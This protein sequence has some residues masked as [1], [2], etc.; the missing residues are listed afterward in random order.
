MILPLPG[1]P[2]I[3]YGRNC[4]TSSHVP[5]LDMHSL[6]VVS[7]CR[8]NSRPAVRAC[9]APTPD[10]CCCHALPSR[11]AGSWPSPSSRAPAAR[12]CPPSCCHCCRTASAPTCFQSC[13]AAWRSYVVQPHRQDACCSTRAEGEMG[14]GRSQRAGPVPA[15]Q[16]CGCVPRLAEG[17]QPSSV[18]NSARLHTR[19]FGQSQASA[20]PHAPQG[21][22]LHI[23]AMLNLSHP[24]CTHL[25]P[26]RPKCTVTDRPAG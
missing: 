13:S 26:P 14:R 17:E 3:P 12:R 19:F 22:L 21:L 24:A 2:G 8:A 10:T 1:I 9:P 15:L 7:T 25:T 16:N 4:F 6:P 23:A 18:C 11:C 5:T 20:P